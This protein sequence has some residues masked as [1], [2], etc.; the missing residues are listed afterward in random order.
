MTASSATVTLPSSTGSHT[1]A[2]STASSS[3]NLLSQLL[4]KPTETANKV[5][6]CHDLPP[7]VHYVPVSTLVSV[8]TGCS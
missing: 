4:T 8:F 1:E 7:T 5:S 3:T 2:D 6:C